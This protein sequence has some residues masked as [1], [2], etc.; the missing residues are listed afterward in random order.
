MTWR[1]Q[2]LPAPMRRAAIVAPDDRFRRVLVEVADAGLFEPDVPS[3]RSPQPTAVT[4][5][6]I[7]NE[8]AT[9]PRLSVDPIPDDM[10]TAA[11]LAAGELLL[12]QRTRATT[13]LSGCAVIAGWT[14]VRHLD[15]LRNVIAP[16][17]GAVVDIPVRRGL[18]A[19]TAHADEKVGEALRPLVTTYAEIPYRN[20]DP[21]LFAAL[22]YVVMFGMMFGDV[23]HGLAILILGVAAQRGHG[24]RLKP[25][26][27]AAPFLIGAGA[28]AI[29]F[30]FLYGEAFGPT[31]LVPTLWLRPLDE[32]EKLLGA[33]LILGGCLLAVTF[34]IASVNRWR[35]AGFAAALYD[36]SGIAGAVLFAGGAAYVVGVAISNSSLSLFGAVLGGIGAILTFLGL[37]VKAGPGGAG[38]AEAIVEMFDTVLRLG[39]N[40]VSF[41]R[42]AAFGLTHAVITG[43]VW[44]GT[45]SLWEDGA[46]LSIAAAGV[47]FVVGNV[48]AFSLGALVGAVQALRLE[49]YEMFSR[50]F[51]AEGRTFDPLHIPVQRLEVT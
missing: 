27:R 38:V 16:H 11:D 12:E 28:A 44:D 24:E 17:G 51:A 20:L 18:A 34:V 43:V 33:G 3:D 31:G 8:A 14:P 10:T 41:T 37:I 46:V 5:P 7:P 4:E 45:V 48:V 42:L 39:S 23:G 13:H 49:Y 29:G 50:L 1:E 26:R 36:A 40:V 22:A 19:P 30:G 25:I 21:T 6:G 35:E 15:A 2:L 47:L 9:I 32:P